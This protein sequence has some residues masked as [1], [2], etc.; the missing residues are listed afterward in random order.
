MFILSLAWL[1]GG[2][3]LGLLVRAAALPL[4]RGAGACWPLW[5]FV[6]VGAAATLA[7]G[8]LGTLL[9]GSLFGSP[10]AIWVGAVVTVCAPYV[11]G[12]A[13][14]VARSRADATAAS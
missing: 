1:L 4:A 9:F 5:R 10:T 3:V 2:A 14:R 7:G 12:L 11:P 6:V 13:R 8:W